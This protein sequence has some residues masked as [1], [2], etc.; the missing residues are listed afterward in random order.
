MATKKADYK[1]WNQMPTAEVWKCVL[2]SM[3]LEPNGLYFHNLRQTLQ[4]I[5]DDN[6]RKLL[7]ITEANI[8]YEKNDPLYVIGL[9]NSSEHLKISL[10]KF[11]AWARNMGWEVPTE[12]VGLQIPG[13]KPELAK[14]PVAISTRERQSLLRIIGALYSVI[15][16]EGGFKKHPGF[17]NQSELITSLVKLYDNVPGVSKS[18]LE[19]VL[20]E[21][22]A[23]LN[24]DPN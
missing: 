3:G 17:V 20:P 2:L 15:K 21:A 23:L 12:L 11:L 1:H 10:T 9:S 22:V 6:F 24:D 14:T 18:N 7:Q 4:P 16:G 5:E 13:A 19:K 8:S